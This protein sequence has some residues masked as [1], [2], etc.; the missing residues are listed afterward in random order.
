MPESRERR[1]RRTATGEAHLEPSLITCVG[2]ESDLALLPHFL[3]H[4]LGLGIAPG[5]VVALL[6]ARAEDSPGLAAADEILAAHGCP[7]GRRWIA[8]YTS[9]AMWAERRRVQAEV[10]GPSDWVVSADV[11]E[12]H[13]YPE[14]LDALLARCDAM[15]VDAVQGPFIDRLSPDG[16]LIEVASDRPVLEQFPVEADVIW[17]IAG[18]GRFHD[19]WGTVKMMAMKGGV[20]PRRG[21]HGAEPDTMRH[22]LTVLPLGDFPG[23]ERPRWRFAV[24]FKVHHIHWV[25][26]LEERLRRRLATRGASVAGSEYGAKQLEHLERHGGISLPHVALDR[27]GRGGPWRRRLARLRAEGR[28]RQTVRRVRGWAARRI[29]STA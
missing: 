22:P 4:Y 17:S 21:G 19:R 12:F 20:L 23:I 8:P 27:G 1:H 3:D 15:G 18:T 16:T 6:N 5:R 9:D 11:D 2:V 29:G 28:A 24:P 10:A 7:P 26:G 25:A 13:A 14:P